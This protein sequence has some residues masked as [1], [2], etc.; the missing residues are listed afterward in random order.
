MSKR[1]PTALNHTSRF[2]IERRWSD[3]PCIPRAHTKYTTPRTPV[4][5]KQS[6]LHSGSECFGQV[7]R[8]HVD[9]RRSIATLPPRKVAPDM[10]SQHLRFLCRDAF[11]KANTP[12][13]EP[14]P[15][16]YTLSAWSPGG[17]PKPYL[18]GPPCFVFIP[19]VRMMLDCQ[20]GYL[21][22]RSREISLLLP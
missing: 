11:Y 22:Y 3:I 13:T 20:T 12:W 17:T 7:K 9:G 8:G 16:P 6:P 1:L 21:T 19:F 10:G 14:T 4:T 18:S 5:S 2:M 15:P